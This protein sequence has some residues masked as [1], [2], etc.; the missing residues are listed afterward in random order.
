M[1]PDNNPNKKPDTKIS[2]LIDLTTGHVV[3][4]GKLGI[5]D[6]MRSFQEAATALGEMLGKDPSKVT[7]QEYLEF[8]QSQNPTEK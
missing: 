5:D 4:G 1:S 2:H 6:M 3:A 7:F 8:L